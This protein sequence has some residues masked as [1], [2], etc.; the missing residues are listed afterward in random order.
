MFLDLDEQKRVT[1]EERFHRI[2][3]LRRCLPAEDLPTGWWDEA[4]IPQTPDIRITSWV[5]A[6]THDI[7]IWNGDARVDP[8]VEW[9]RTRFASL[10]LP[11]PRPS[12][13]TFLPPVAGD[14]WETFGFLT[15][16]DAPDLG[17]PFTGP[18]VCP[19][20]PCRW[21]TAI[22]AAT[23]HESPTCG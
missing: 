12:S 14:R 8:I 22:R 21:S 15:G 11:P 2:D 10:G 19:D 13:V 6:P 1:H 16:T 7:A 20:G 23:L 9:A 17:L 5:S 4:R 18:E 3:A